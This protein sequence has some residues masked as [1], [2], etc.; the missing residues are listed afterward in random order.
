MQGGIKGADIKT[1]GRVRGAGRGGI[2][3]DRAVYLTAVLKRFV[4]IVLTECA[5]GLE[6]ELTH[7]DIL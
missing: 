2:M 6:T 4:Q 3:K 7:N 1:K 5:F